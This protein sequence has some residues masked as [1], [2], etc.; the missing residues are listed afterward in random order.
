MAWIKI[1]KEHHPIFL[2]AL[3]RDPRS[4]TRPMFGSL[5]AMANGYMYGGLFAHGAF[6]R[7][8]AAGGQEVLALD[9][10]APFDPMGR[11]GAMRDLYTLP[12]S[13]LDEPG[14]LRGWL[15]RAFAYAVALPPKPVKKPAAKKQPAAKKKPAAKKP[16]RGRR[17]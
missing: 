5:C 9:G 2:A 6:V 15:A 1:P 17:V 3:P 10:G 14:E 16:S 13:V 4:T 11:G 12:D 8:D 7:L